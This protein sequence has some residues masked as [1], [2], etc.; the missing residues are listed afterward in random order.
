MQKLQDYFQLYFQYIISVYYFQYIQY[1][2]VYFQYIISVYL[3]WSDSD[4]SKERQAEL[5]KSEKSYKN[6]IFSE[7]NKEPE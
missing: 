2:S 6:K 3:V 4:Q 7:R 1:I 5:R